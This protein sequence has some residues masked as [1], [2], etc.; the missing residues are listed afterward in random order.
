MTRLLRPG[1]GDLK[2]GRIGR[3]K[4]RKERGKGKKV[5]KI[6]CSFPGQGTLVSCPCREKT[7]DKRVRAAATGSGPLVRKWVGPSVL[8]MVRMSVTAKNSSPESPF[9]AGRGT[10][11][12]V[13]EW[14]FILTLRNELSK[15]TYELTKQETSLKGVPR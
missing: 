5:S 4:E 14:A 1:L 9:I 15:E 13:Q 2:K 6:S 12:R 11:S 10:P 7:R 8:Q 3:V